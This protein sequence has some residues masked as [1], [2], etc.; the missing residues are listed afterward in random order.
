MSVND[1]IEPSLSRAKIISFVE[2]YSACFYT[3]CSG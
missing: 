3:V 1:P 2:D